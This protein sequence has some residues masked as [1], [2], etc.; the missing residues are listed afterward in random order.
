MPSN[1]PSLIFW[2]RLSPWRRFLNRN[3]SLSITIVFKQRPCKTREE[4]PQNISAEQKMLHS[5]T[6]SLPFCVR[7]SAFPSLVLDARSFRLS[8][9]PVEWNVKET[10]NIWW[11]TLQ[12][13]GHLLQWQ[14]QLTWKMATI[15]PK[16]YCQSVLS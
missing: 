13:S 7:G 4:V 3:V 1:Y 15:L 6:S 9:V 2:M 10:Q 12:S 5:T 16:W 8:G 11:I 14:K